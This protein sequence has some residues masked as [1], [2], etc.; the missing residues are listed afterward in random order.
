LAPCPI[1]GQK[2]R[3]LS[4]TAD[5]DQLID[6]RKETMQ[7]DHYEISRHLE[8]LLP[9]A[10]KLLEK[11]VAINS[12]TANREGVN[13]LG[14]LTA[15]IYAE[16]GFRSRFVP[17]V[18]RER[19]D[20]LILESD[21]RSAG[22]QP[23][24]AMISHLD[25]VF[26]EE[27]ERRNHFYWRQEG[28]R[29][30]GPGTVDI[31]GGT[32]IIYLVLL[33]LQALYPHV[34]ESTRWILLFNAAEEIL[35]PGFGQTARSIIPLDALACLVFEAGR[36]RE[37]RFSI[38]AARKGMA[39]Y[40]V[41]A[42]GK[43]AH[44]GSSHHHGANAITQ[45]ARAVD[46]IAELTDYERNITFN[47]GSFQGG[48][49]SNRVPHHAVARGE[50]RAYSASLMEEGINSLLSLENNNSVKSHAG[51]YSCSVRVKIRQRWGPWPPNESTDALLALWQQAA[52]EM[53]MEVERQERGGLSDANF[54]WDHVPT[55]DGL[56][57]SGGNAHCSERSADGT[58]E[59]EYLD[60]PSIVPKATLNVLALLRLLA[61]HV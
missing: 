13:E 39:T 41:E 3:I 52:H 50:L 58:K 21:G 9:D 29:I 61:P 25:T 54:I 60:A 22:E 32:I 57:P 38:V 53:G 46:A 12:F 17:T 16:L 19:G 45:L 14:K 27:E 47:V 31:K 6:R 43:A 30:Y 7:V 44:A 56:G 26:P 48:T 20:H 49:V 5:A 42:E 51:D 24:I 28:D 55:L 10:L 36:M 37:K 2:G 1:G 15:E 8:G 40:Q 18:N 23:V 11:M 59:Q 35:D 34:F 4:E 33:T